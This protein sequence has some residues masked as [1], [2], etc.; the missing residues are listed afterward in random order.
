LGRV[1]Q[2]E[3]V[4]TPRLPESVEAIGAMGWTDM[5]HLAVL[6]CADQIE[7]V[8]AQGGHAAVRERLA[9]LSDGQRQVLSETLAELAHA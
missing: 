9:E 5:Q 4:A 3:E 8:L 1:P 7:S 6:L 2:S